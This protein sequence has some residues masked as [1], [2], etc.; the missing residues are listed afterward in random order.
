M[1]M[2]GMRLRGGVAIAMLGA[3]AATD[4]GTGDDSSGTPQPTTAPAEDGGSSSSSAAVEDGGSTTTT[5]PAETG[6]SSEGNG[7]G[8]KLD[9]GGVAS[10][11]GEDTGVVDDC[12]CEN[13]EDGIYVLDSN[14]PAS[15]QFYNPLSNTFSLVGVLGCAAPLGATAN[16]MAIDRQG[17]AW[18]NYYQLGA[19]NTGLLY[20]AAL[21]DLGNC[22]DQGY[23]GSGAWFL[24]G[25]GYSV[26]VPDGSCDTLYLYNSDQYI[27]N[28][29][30]VG[31]SAIASWDED[32]AELDEIG[33]TDY[34]VAELSGT[35]DARLFAFATVSAG[36]T[37]LA[38]LDK[39][40]GSA[41]EVT[42]LVGLDI[43]NAFAFA[44]WGGDVYFFT[45]GGLFGSSQI[46]RLDY[47]GTGDLE[48]VEPDTGM[49]ITGAG[50]S[51]CASFEPPN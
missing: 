31:G 44:F 48:V 2:M 42:P 26:D 47:D 39:D 35:G 21:D 49:N 25:M 16:S 45:Q 9:V 27:N 7:D 51:T 1:I 34:P 5:T 38:E 18:I 11:S 40:D 17:N 32:D 14:A 50:V 41:I 43:G 6:S 30:Y 13:V 36:E 28:P 10:E 15:V 3:C 4:G 37:V 22:V 19:P 46:T 23:M 8:P 20:R 24:L 12:P 33:P 29:N